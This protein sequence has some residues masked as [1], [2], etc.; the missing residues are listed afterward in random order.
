MVSRKA[1]AGEV[2]SRKVFR[3][4]VTARKVFREEV[5][6]E[7]SGEEEPF[8]YLRWNLLHLQEEGGSEL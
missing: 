1:A 5:T 4:E 2:T 7:R 6:R 8:L 3:E